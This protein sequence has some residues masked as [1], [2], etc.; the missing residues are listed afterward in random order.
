MDRLVDRSERV[1]QVWAYTVGMRRLLLRSTKTETFST[2]IDVLFQNV[3]ALM[4]ATSIEGLVVGPAGEA[5]SE[6]ITA[7]TSLLP[8]DGTHFYRVEMSA[9]SGYVVAGVVVE[10]EDSGEYF[11]PS[12]Y[13][14]GPEGNP[15]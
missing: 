13:W 10:D 12:K 3:K 4:L 1:F 8:D 7:D 9:G 6:R 2:R 5:L 11:E 14:P 15:G